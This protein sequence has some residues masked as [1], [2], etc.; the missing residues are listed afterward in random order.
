MTLSELQA[1]STMVWLIA[2][3]REEPTEAQTS[4]G[5]SMKQKAELLTDALHIFV[6]CI[7]AIA[8][9]LFDLLSQNAEL[10]WSTFL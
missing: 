1:R 2:S 3:R 6:L 10:T 8:Q 9:P 4:T 7:F 5:I